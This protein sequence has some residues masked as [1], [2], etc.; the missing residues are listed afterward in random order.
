MKWRSYYTRYL[1]FTGVAAGGGMMLE[2][3]ITYGYIL[4][5]WPIDH[6]TVGLALVIAG[7][8]AAGGKRGANAHDTHE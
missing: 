1:G 7:A 4:H 3:Y 8:I 2:H 6:G 5:M